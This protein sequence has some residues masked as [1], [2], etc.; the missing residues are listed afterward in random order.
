[1]ILG[2]GI[3]HIV[4]IRVWIAETGRS[5]NPLRLEILHIIRRELIF[6]VV[7]RIG[8]RT[9]TINLVWVVEISRTTNS[10][11]LN[12][13]DRISGDLM[14][15]I[16]WSI[17]RCTRTSNWVLAVVISRN[18]HAA[19]LEILPITS[20][21]LVLSVFCG[22]GWRTR[23]RNC[24][25]RSIIGLLRVVFVIVKIFGEIPKGTSGTRCWHCSI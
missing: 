21:G 1:M 2:I 19:R 18:A 5:T 16:V 14:L 8:W 24:S 11:G 13:S 6:S 3:I 20:R 10:A 9:C 22:I 23:T 17:S 25:R 15:S 4:S 7:W 12:I